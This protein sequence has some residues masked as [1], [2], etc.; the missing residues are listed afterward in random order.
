MST[1]YAMF[2]TLLQLIYAVLMQLGTLLTVPVVLSGAQM[3]KDISFH[4]C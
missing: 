1:H 3:R 4:W 2:V